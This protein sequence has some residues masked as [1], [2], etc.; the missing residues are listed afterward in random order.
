M[1]KAPGMGTCGY[2]GAITITLARFRKEH[3]VALTRSYPASTLRR[4]YLLLFLLSG[5]S[6]LI[7]QS[8]WT[9]Y[10]KLFL[11]HAAYA[12]TLVLSI[13]MGGMAI[14]AWWASKLTLRWRQPLLAYAVTEM[15]VGI[16]ALVFHPVFM[17]VTNWSYDSVIPSLGNHYWVEVWKWALAGLLILPQSVLL[18]A[19]F[20]FMSAGLLRRLVH[21]PGRVIGGLYFANSLGAAVGVLV[22]GFVLID[23]VGLPGTVTTAGFINIVLA[24]AIYVLVRTD[25]AVVSPAASGASQPAAHASAPV[26]A[27]MMVSLLTGL[28][29]F[30]YEIGWI[31]ML[32]MVLGSSTHAFELMLSAF[33]TGIAIGGFWV[34]RH[35]DRFANP[36]WALAVIQ[37][38]MGALAITTLLVYGQ[39]FHIMQGLLQALAKTESGYLLF[40]LS[41]HGI[42]LLVML[43]ATICAGMTLPIITHVLV[44]RGV[45]EVAIGRVYA[46]N[47]VGAILGVVLAVQLVMPLLGLK[48]LIVAGGMVDIALGVFLLAMT[49]D[50]LPAWR[51]WG[52]A[53]SCLLYAVVIAVTVPLD[54]SKMASG[55]F[56]YG[57][58]LAAH[59][60]VLYH[61]DG[62]T[63]T[64]DV[65]AHHD[66]VSIRTNGKSDAGLVLDED[67]A[68]SDESTMALLAAIPLMTHPDIRHAAVIGLGSGMSTDTLLRYPGIQQVDTV[69]IE[70]GMVEG[71]RQ[72]GNKVAK[73]FT[74]PRSTIHIADAKT[75]FTSHQSRYDL[76]LS[77]PSNPWVSGVAGLFSVEF[78]RLASR[79]LNDGGLFA[80]WFHVYEINMPVLASVGKSLAAVF[81]NYR[82]YATSGGDLLLLASHQ[83]LAAP[84]LQPLLGTDLAQRLALIGIHT[85]SDVDWTYLGD[86]TVM[87][88]LFESYPVP[89]NSDYY[90]YVDQHAVKARFLRENAGDMMTLLP[91]AT[92]PLQQGL[93]W[94]VD[95]P[96]PRHPLRIA[97]SIRSAQQQLQY[98]DSRQQ[99]LPAPEGDWLPQG[100]ENMQLLRLPLDTPKACDLLVAQAVWL[101]ALQE[102]I[103]NI[104]RH[105]NPSQT[106]RVWQALLESDCLVTWSGEYQQWLQFALAQSQG[107]NARV[108]EEGLQ[109]LA[110]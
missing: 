72:L 9:H 78:Y 66:S 57:S 33:I 106:T 77:E 71:A 60:Q 18:G 15:V 59:E 5:F 6:G 76:I 64:V 20:P 73:A 48:S 35:I 75:F 52:V 68:G 55:V 16:L 32:S 90:P 99:G 41:S 26:Q 28:A 74:D 53:A 95:A 65:V 7:Y 11:G 98:W 34:R 110:A 47:T 63:A 1:P 82:V 96:G 79:H 70:P 42:A 3:T 4:L 13:F 81:P 50:A 101:P 61:H 89:M 107:D 17:G 91:F 84:V 39:T 29:S 62:K 58:M 87:G 24:L 31:R 2:T 30:F 105:V 19:T 88:P 12:Q 97:G 44:T 108:I 102:F 67:R 104:H 21:E 43:P 54:T 86:H 40:N 45:G 37:L 94:P 56:R 109:L 23:R 92:L 8:I 27:L 10:L 25:A 83:P 93:S 100:V 22:A 49:R 36:L 69:E 80:Q 38:V 85:Q 103:A 51:R 46:V 14:G